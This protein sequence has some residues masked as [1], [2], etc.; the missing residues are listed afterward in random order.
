MIIQS[1][2]FILNGN[3]VLFRCA[4]ENDGQIMMDYLK[5]VSEETRYLLREP[6]EINV[7]LE[8][9]L[10]FINSYN[11]SD[12]NLLVLAF[13]NGEYA[14]NS[15]FS[16]AGPSRRNQHR[17]D[18]GIALYQRFTSQGIGSALFKFM[19]DEARLAGFEQC[20]L[21]VVSTN[22]KA[23]HLYKKLGFVECG[24][25]TNANKYDDGTYSDNIFMILNLKG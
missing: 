10:S 21:T 7:T 18:I 8:Q 16:L 2:Q 25:I 5:T 19:I 17:V 11:N 22:E 13:V 4:N 23:I 24:R 6:D 1:K 12:T 15:S 9:E 20:E 14:G 3:E